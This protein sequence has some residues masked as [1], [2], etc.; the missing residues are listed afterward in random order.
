MPCGC[1]S[2]IV[3]GIV[4]NAKVAAQAIGIPV[5][6]APPEIVKQRWDFCRECPHASKDKRLVDRPS[7]GLVAL[8]RCRHPDCGC[9]IKCKTKLA[10]ESCPIGKWPAVPSITETPAGIPAGIKNLPTP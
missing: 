7:K 8:S 1:G 4:G 3:K 10:S 5:D 9:L 6:Q 2:R